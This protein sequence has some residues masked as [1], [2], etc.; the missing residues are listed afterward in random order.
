MNKKEI[1]KQISKLK[2]KIVN[3][4]SQLENTIEDAIK[5]AEIFSR[6]LV[7]LGFN[8]DFMQV[9]DDGMYKHLGFYLGSVEDEKWKVVVDEYDCQVLIRE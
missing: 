2:L 6:K 7:T 3:L 1:Q 8:D 9:R 4:E 5:P